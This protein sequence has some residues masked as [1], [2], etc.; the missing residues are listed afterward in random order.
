MYFVG[1]DLAWS[2]RNTTAVAV[3]EGDSQEASLLHCKSDL[4]SDQEITDFIDQCVGFTPALVAIDAPLKVPN[5]TG[6]RP[7]DRRIT[8]VFGQFE[9]G[10]FPA[11]RSRWGGGV[12]SESM[13]QYLLERGFQHSYRLQ[14][15]DKRRIFFEVY[16]HP[17]MVSLF[18]LDKTLKYKARGGRS[19]EHRYEEYKRYQEYLKD[20]TNSE[21]KLVLNEERF[22][23]EVSALRGKDL[24][25][26]EDLLDAI[27]CA[28][29]AYYAWYWGPERYETYGDEKEGSII[30]PMTPC[31]EES[32]SH[33]IERGR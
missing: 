19:Y 31:D 23:K 5:E 21:P 10:A 1:I 8:E 32:C 29:V 7:V 11:N 17:A 26:Y 24:K 28:Y 25:T 22:A 3:A 13:V 15:R 12:R 4:G 30:V 27:F 16:P 20:L 2:V 33:G 14:R 18:H 6:S 9:A